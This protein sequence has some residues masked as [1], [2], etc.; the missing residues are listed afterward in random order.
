MDAGLVAVWGMAGSGLLLGFGHCTAM[1]GPLVGSLAHSAAPA[2][3]AR[4]ALGQ[5]A[6]HAGRL[7]TY[8]ALGG[9]MGLTGAFVNV[10]GRLGG[11]TQAVGLAAGV[12]LVVVGLAA[13]GVLRLPARWLRLEAGL[14]GRLGRIVRALREDGG[15]GRLYPVGLVL[16][17]LP[18]GASWTAFLSAAGAGSLPLG[19]ATALAFGVGTLPGL[20]LVGLAAGAIGAQLRRGLYRVGGV[21]VTAVG[22]WYVLR[23]VGVLHA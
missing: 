11:V 23:A 1:C 19:A 13:A 18:C 3:S 8:A 21:A 7:T 12:L 20:L 22:V 5:L 4:S 15:P 9:A 14:S 16:G 17:F 2:G 10:A 6:Y